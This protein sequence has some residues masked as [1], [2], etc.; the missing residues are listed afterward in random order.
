[1]GKTGNKNVIATDRYVDTENGTVNRRIFSDPDIYQQEMRQ[2]FARSWNFMCHTSQIPDPGSYFLNSI[3]EDQVIIV[4]DREGE[5]NVFLNSC[6]A[7]WEYG[8]PRGAR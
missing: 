6:H 4:R 8:L 1:M 7:S 3:G 2:I 5:V